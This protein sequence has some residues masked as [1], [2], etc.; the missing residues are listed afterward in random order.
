MQADGDIARVLTE[1]P[2][3]CLAPAENRTVAETLALGQIA[4]NSPA[5]LGGQAEK[6]GLS[7]ASCHRNG[8]G[9]PDF[10]MTAVS[11]EPGTA[12]VTS[13][14]FSTVRADNVF[15]PVPIPDLALREG[16][17]QVDRSD[18]A[19][20]ARFVRGQIEEEFSG[21]RAPEP[22]F[23]ALLT[24]LQYIDADKSSCDPLGSVNALWLTDWRRAETAAREAARSDDAAARAFY[25]RSARLSLGR[26]HDRH[27]APEDTA[28]RADLIALSRLLATGAPWPDEASD[29]RERLE[30]RA[31]RS[32]Y[33]PA[34]LARA[35]EDLSQPQR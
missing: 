6:R 35:L 11:A 27:I 8:R 30:A 28:L 20:L 16:R 9:N 17:D 15:N 12:D 25:I 23:E 5:L 19:A 21:D 2:R 14:L 7:C 10:Q 26:L 24:Y 33:S 22:V 13:G 34:V 4:F 32:L 29:L 18:R 31:G 3:A 1:M